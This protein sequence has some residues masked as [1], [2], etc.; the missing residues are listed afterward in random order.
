[1]GS[2]PGVLIEDQPVGFKMK[3]DSGLLGRRLV[4]MSNPLGIR[5]QVNQHLALRVHNSRCWIVLEIIPGDP[6][7]AAGILAVNDDLDVVQ[8]RPSALLELHRLGSTHRKLSAA[9]Y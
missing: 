5:F 2:V 1:R 9:F 6:V 8:V 7:K 3:W 4:G